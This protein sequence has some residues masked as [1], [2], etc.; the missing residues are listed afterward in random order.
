MR[1]TADVVDL[2]ARKALGRPKVRSDDEQMEII[3]AK[4]IEL[5]L[6]VGFV[7]MRMDDVAAACRVSKRTLYRLFPSK[8]DLFRAM[9]GVHRQS[10]L[11]FPAIE[12]RQTL[13]EALAEVF[14]IDIDAEED[15]RRMAFIHRTLAETR[16]VPELGDV[17]HQ[18]GGEKAKSLLGAW[19]AVWKERDAAGIGDPH[20]A[21]SILMDMVFGAIALKPSDV[22]YWPGGSDRKAYLR[23][24]FRYFVNGVK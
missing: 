6:D 5:F 7:A 9:A 23:E 17:L 10:M 3:V 1:K 19:L 18:E 22:S 15:R 24:C 16:V 8:L 4:A 12:G 21:A 20:A 14:R 11:I 13:E 2:G